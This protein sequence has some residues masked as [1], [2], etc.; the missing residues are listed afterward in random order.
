MT[1]SLGIDSVVS[2]TVDSLVGYTGSVGVK[3]AIGSD[4]I[5]DSTSVQTVVGSN[6]ISDSVGSQT[7]IGSVAISGSV[8]PQP[9]IGPV[10]NHASDGHKTSVT[11]NSVNLLA[12][13]EH[14][15]VISDMDKSTKGHSTVTPTVYDIAITQDTDYGL[16]PPSGRN[17]LVEFGK[18][19]TELCNSD[20]EHISHLI[21]LPVHP[22]LDLQLK[23]V[24]RKQEN[25]HYLISWVSYLWLQLRMKS[26]SKT[27]SH[28]LLKQVLTLFKLLC[29]QLL[30]WPSSL[31]PLQCVI[32]FHKVVSNS[33]STFWSPYRNQIK[34]PNLNQLMNEVCPLW[35]Y[36]SNH[37]ENA[38]GRFILIW[39]PHMSAVVILS[40]KQSMTC[41]ITCLHAADFFY[42]PVYA[43]NTSEERNDLWIE[44][45][46]LQSY[47]NAGSFPWLI[48]GDFNEIFH[49]SEHFPAGSNSFTKQMIDFKSCI[50]QMKMRD[51]RYHGTKFSW[52]NKQSDNLIAR[53]LDRALI[54]ES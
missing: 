15:M 12:V 18:V 19:S 24:T 29:R 32:S 7:V 4:G 36:T 51:L 9:V 31:L 28:A 2:K 14:D 41:K 53:K 38:N 37:N 34:E 52:T 42:T 25:H 30:V 6:G 35:S 11:T 16:S 48:G 8:G 10:G 1:G 27:P 3:I 39:K 50:D 54:N 44:L 22:S 40:T 23:R 13:V 49:P 20:S 47:L 26:K 45:L 17:D 21:V 33:P 43:A 5:T 46:D